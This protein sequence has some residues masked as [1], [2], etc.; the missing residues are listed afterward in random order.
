MTFTSCQ[1]NL[2]ADCK[3]SLWRFLKG[4]YCVYLYKK[5]NSL[6]SRELEDLPRFWVMTWQPFQMPWSVSQ[7]N[8]SHFLRGSNCHAGSY[9]SVGQNLWH[10]YTGCYIPRNL[11]VDHAAAPSLIHIMALPNKGIVSMYRLVLPTS[12][13]WPDKS[14]QESYLSFSPDNR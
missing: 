3:D 11:Q 14:D 13:A 7:M 2:A 6:N 10:K 12:F 5:Y 9:G 8:A 4:A 1:K